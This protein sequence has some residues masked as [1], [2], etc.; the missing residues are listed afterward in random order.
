MAIARMTRASNK[1]QVINVPA[2]IKEMKVYLE[3]IKGKKILTFE[4]TTPAQ[5]LYTELKSYVDEIIVCDPYRNHLLQEGPKTDKI[6][7]T[8]LV[9]LLKG[10]L[11]KAV[12]HTAEEFIYLRN[13]VSGY[14]DIVKAGVRLK[15]ERA[16]LL[17]SQGKLKNEKELDQPSLK[18][19][20]DGIDR[21]IESYEKEKARYENEFS[22]LRKT[23]KMLSHLTSIPGIGEINAVKIAARV[24]DPKRFTDK[25]HLWSYCGL[26]KLDR[27]SGGRS[28]GKK[29]SRFC[30]VLKSVFKTA[31]MTVINGNTN[32]PLKNYY[33]DLIEKGGYAKHN[34]RN[35]VARRICVLAWGVMKGGK[36]YD[37]NWKLMKCKKIA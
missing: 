7:A 6:D 10:G 24:V 11:L 2:S 22:R 28:Y 23:H 20:L 30:R 13:I 1:V 17:R 18:F 8:K 15:N 3:Q 12:Y 19:V 35:A 21:G 32:H 14:E 4:E 16:A 36:K 25:G 29:S 26:V 27:V 37:S 9:R 31:S 5:W 33:N 34:A